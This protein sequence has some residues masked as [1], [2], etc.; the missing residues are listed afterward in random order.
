MKKTLK[1]ALK[2]L[3]NEEAQGKLQPIRRSYPSSFASGARETAHSIT[4]WLARWV[5]TPLNPSAMAE[6]AGQPPV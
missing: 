5:T 3:P 2:S 6:Q 4:S 1:S